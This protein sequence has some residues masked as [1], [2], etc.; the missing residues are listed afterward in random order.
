MNR[1]SAVK[2]FAM[3]N[4]LLEADLDKIEDMYQID[5]GRQ[6]RSRTKIEDAYY[7]QFDS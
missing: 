7:P 3:T 4:M 6:R 1:S 5:L 2:S